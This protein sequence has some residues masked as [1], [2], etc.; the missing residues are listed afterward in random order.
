MSGSEGPSVSEDF[1]QRLKVFEETVGSLGE[2]GTWSR[3]LAKANLYLQSKERDGQTLSQN[4]LMTLFEKAA[5][6]KCFIDAL[7]A[8]AELAAAA[9]K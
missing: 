3:S 8:A 6:M 7:K 9:R 5:S 4:A 2:P 1:N